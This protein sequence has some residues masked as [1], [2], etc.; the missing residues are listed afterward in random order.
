[1]DYV[2]NSQIPVVAPFANSNDVYGFSNL[3]ITETNEQIYADRIVEEVK[4]VYQDQK[5][6]IVADD[7]GNNADYLKSGLEKQL[8]NPNIILVKYPSEIKFD[9]NMMTGQSVSV[10][11]ILANNEDNAGES[12]GNR[13]AEL[14]KEGTGTKAFSMY[15]SPIFEKKTQELGAVNLVYLMDRKIN[16]EGEFEKEI[17]ENFKKK[18][19]KTP[20]KYNVIGFD[21]T[22]DML[23][24]ENKKGEIFPQMEKIQTQLATKFEFGRIGNGAFVNKGVRVIR[25]TR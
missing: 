22:N 13:M 4:N 12:F 6:Y 25:L 14:G 24:R 16:N 9:K 3:I 21:I 10:I 15:F 19:C 23:S 17:I 5:I 1:L 11:A 7:S 18:Y 2:G 20:S 8:K